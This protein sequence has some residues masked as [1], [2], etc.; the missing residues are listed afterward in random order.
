MPNPLGGIP[1]DHYVPQFYLDA[2]AIEGPGN[3]NSHIYQY[4]DDK[5]VSPRISDVASERHFYTA[6]DKKGKRIR[7]IDQFITEVEGDAAT[8]LKRIIEKKNLNLSDKNL[9]KIAIFLATLATRTPS[10]VKEIQS[11]EAETIKEFMAIKAIDIN[12]LRESMKK[13]GVSLSEEKLREQQKFM[14]EKKYSIGF[15]DQLK[16][17]S[18]FIAKG[19]EIA[20]NIAQLF[21]EKKHWHLLI[22]KSDRVFVTSDNPVSIYR[23]IFVPPAMNAGYANGTIVIPISPKMA[24][25]LRNIP[26]KR[27]L[28]NI[29]SQKINY[30]NKNTMRFSDNYIFSNL[31]SKQINR[32]FKETENKQPQKVIVQRLRWAPY[33]FMGAPPMKEELI[34]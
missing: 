21:Y 16:S 19:I 9:E 15:G 2:F 7:D 13:I 10:F 33:I 18:H 1:K 11:L 14:L 12:V 20:M 34:F 28:I 5:I 25:A 26:Y 22:S 30:I 17:R 32:F 24:I 8:P 4:M 27:Q 6:E 3:Q 23:P 29:D 31:K